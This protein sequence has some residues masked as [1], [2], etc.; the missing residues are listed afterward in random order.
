MTSLLL[1]FDPGISAEQNPSKHTC[2]GNSGA[3]VCLPGSLDRRQ[4]RDSSLHRFLGGD[5]E[6]VIVEAFCIQQ[7]L[8]RNELILR[9]WQLGGQRQLLGGQP[10]DKE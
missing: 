1:L 10:E 5:Y 8:R 2:G 3:P 9:T 4:A 7:P 6:L